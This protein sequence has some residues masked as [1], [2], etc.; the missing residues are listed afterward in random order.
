MVKVD[1]L[2]QVKLTGEFHVGGEVFLYQFGRCFGKAI[3]ETIS[4]VEKDVG[5]VRITDYED[6][7]DNEPRGFFPVSS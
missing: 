3:V 5:I 4:T 7:R 1:D 2:V 6:L